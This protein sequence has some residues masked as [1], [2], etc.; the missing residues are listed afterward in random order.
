MTTKNAGTKAYKTNGATN[1]LQFLQSLLRGT[2]TSITA[3][4]AGED[5]DIQKFHARIFELKQA[6]LRIRTK[7]TGTHKELA[8]KVSARNLLGS[9]AK[10]KF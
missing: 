3:K 7:R 5:F 10:I 6:G 1:Q 2:N 9:R 4:Q 8:Y